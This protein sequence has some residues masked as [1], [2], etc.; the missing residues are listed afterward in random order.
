MG[1]S[2]S[3]H[4]AAADLVS[5]AK[6]PI[7][8]SI[9]SKTK[10]DGAQPP[11]GL[12]WKPTIEE[13]R[14]EDGSVLFSDGSIVEDIDAIIYCTGY[15][16]SFP[17]WNE[18]ANGRPLWDYKTD[19][20]VGNYQH[21]F[22]RDYPT[23]GIVGLPRTLTFRSFEYQAIALARLWSNRNKFPLPDA[24]KQEEWELERLKQSQENKTKFHNIPWDTGETHGYLNYLY[25]FAGLP[26]LAGDGR[27]PP[28]LT[29]EMVWA[30]ENIRKYPEP[31]KDKRATPT[32]VQEDEYRGWI[33]V[34]Q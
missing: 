23:I 29:R 3:G 6:K 31:G 7:Y 25:T 9:R 19:R 11:P 26:T 13:F 5:V 27:V 14:R 20:M 22:L 4:D 34:R 1:N 33:V 12:E 28:A 18:A 16:S 21:T 8:W 24:A 32:E 30:I 15:K 10:W 17:F 2:A